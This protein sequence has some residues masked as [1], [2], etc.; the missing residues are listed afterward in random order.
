MSSINKT[1]LLLCCV[2]CCC[3]LFCVFCCRS[4]CVFLLSFPVLLVFAGFF[5]LSFLL[6]V[7][8]A[9]FVS[10]FFYRFCVVR[11]VVFLCVLLCNYANGSLPMSS[12]AAGLLKKQVA[13]MKTYHDIVAARISHQTREATYG[14]EF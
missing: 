10:L 2:F 8:S 12:H 3:S 13:T 1:P 4:C 6:V 7:L 9:F 14:T 5:S 11:R